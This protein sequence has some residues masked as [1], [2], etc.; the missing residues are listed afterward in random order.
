MGEAV[1]HEGVEVILVNHETFL[2]DQ[3]FQNLNVFSLEEEGNKEAAEW[4]VKVEFVS[5][6]NLSVDEGLSETESFNQ[7][8]QAGEALVLDGQEDWVEFGDGDS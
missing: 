6:H 1:A 3:I 5:N 7:V 4:I 2:L 8:G